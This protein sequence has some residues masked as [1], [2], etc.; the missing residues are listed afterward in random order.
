M[1]LSCGVEA[2]LELCQLTAA[3]VL[4][5]DSRPLRTSTAARQRSIRPPR[6]LQL[7][8]PGLVAIH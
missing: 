2:A 3:A 5:R 4:P 6:K 8:V 1:V 7:A